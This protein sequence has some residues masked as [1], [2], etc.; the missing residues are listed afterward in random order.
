[1]YKKTSLSLLS[2][3]ALFINPMFAL[4]F[5]DVPASDPEY[6]AV[7]DVVS[8]GIASGYD[9]NYFGP[10]NNVTRAEATKFIANTVGLYCDTYEGIEP[11]FSDTA[12]AYGLKKYITCFQ[13]RGFIDGYGDGRFG[14]Q[15]PVR[16]SEFF[17]M[18][19]NAAGIDPGFQNPPTFYDLTDLTLT[20]YVAFAM[21]W[22]I[23]NYSEQEQIGGKTKINNINLP[24]RYVAR[25]LHNFI[26][27]IPGRVTGTYEIPG[28]INGNGN[29]YR[30][31]D[32]GFQVQLS[33]SWDGFTTIQEDNDVTILVPTTDPNWQ[34]DRAGY[35]S[36]IVFSVFTIS[37]WDQ[38]QL[39][40]G[41]KPV[42]LGTNEDLYKV[43]VYSTFQ[44]LPSDLEY[45]NF[46]IMAVKET[47]EIL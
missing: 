16:K 4:A 36:I 1:M 39:E 29:V 14:P 33:S 19:I 42:Y 44:A 21:D 37:E 31:E 25:Y 20:P 28:V 11:T 30:N 10:N 38:I 27:N 47:F 22:S 5:I 43:Y 17:K 12:S 34:D 26:E 24:R 7:S 9:S 13:S 35:A 6:E 45:A 41:P 3:I 46:D 18:L 2:L 15:D 8:R 40:D 23:M 32:L